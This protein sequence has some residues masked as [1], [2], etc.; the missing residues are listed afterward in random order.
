MKGKCRLCGSDA[1]LQRSHI[2]PAFVF[3]WLRE[4]SATGHIRLGDEPNRR[5]QDGL[6]RRWLC[7][8]CENLLCSTERQFSQQIFKPVVEDRLEHLRY[9][10]W[11]LKFCVSLSWRV[12]CYFQEIDQFDDYS[13]EDCATLN[14]AAITWKKYLLGQSADILGTFRQHLY[15]VCG[16]S[17]AKHE[18]A[19]NLNL[20]ILRHIN[21][22]IVLGRDQHIVYVKLPRIFIVGTLRDE[23]PDQWQGTEIYAEGGIIP[24][25]QRVPDALYDYVNHKAERAGVLSG[26]MSERQKAKVDADFYSDPVRAGE[27]DTLNAL[28]RDIALSY[29]KDENHESS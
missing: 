16:V 18:I 8:P 29:Q 5:V 12:L 15:V 6:W 1:E 10:P 4:S 21:A 9:G 27:S 20:H 3:R 14:Q 7:S 23:C 24:H 22:D 17:S 25:T 19:P 13:Q 11:L 2:I 26:S 28:L